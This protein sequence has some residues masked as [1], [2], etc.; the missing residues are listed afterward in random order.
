MSAQR[1]D[2]VLTEL[3]EPGTRWSTIRGFRNYLRHD[4]AEMDL[5]AVGHA[6]A[7]M[8]LFDAGVSDTIPVD[9]RRNSKS[10]V[11]ARIN[12]GL[13]SKIEL[14]PLGSRWILSDCLQGHPSYQS[15]TMLE[16]AEPKKK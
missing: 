3:H 14:L 4:Y 12:L 1:L 8:D 13:H 9:N 7:D 2:T 16:I 15:N 11:G 10:R 5:N 6:V